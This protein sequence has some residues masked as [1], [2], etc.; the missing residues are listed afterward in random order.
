MGFWGIFTPKNAVFNVKMRAFSQAEKHIM[1]NVYLTEKIFFANEISRRELFVKKITVSLLIVLT[2]FAVVFSAFAVNA[3]AEDSSKAGESI[4]DSTLIDYGYLKVFKEELKKEILDEIAQNGG[5]SGGSGYTDVS[6]T[7]GQMVILSPNCEIIFRGGSAVAV[8]SSCF[9][10]E[11]ITDVS[12]NTELFSG[13]PLEFG[14]IYYP[15]GSSAKKAILITG[16]TAH[17]T[18]KGS[19]EIV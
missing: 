15:S 5:L 17:F 16:Q 10:G 18:L 19:Y 6:L 2:A 13:M 9:D 7:E 11:G 8:T 4:P 14:H 12:V 3:P 1:V